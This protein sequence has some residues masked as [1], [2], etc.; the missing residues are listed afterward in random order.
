MS[1]NINVRNCLPLMYLRDGLRD[2]SVCI[3]DKYAFFRDK[4]KEGFKP[5]ASCNWFA[6]SIVDR[7]LSRGAS[8]CSPIRA[9]V[10]DVI[11]ST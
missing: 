5:K 1:E 6:L 8:P 11:A 4:F 9:S 2:I 10:F 3:N 7:L